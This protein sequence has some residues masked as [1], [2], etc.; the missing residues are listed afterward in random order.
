MTDNFCGWGNF[1]ATVARNSFISAILESMYFTTSSKL[2]QVLE[3]LPFIAVM[4]SSMASTRF[5]SDSKDLPA[6]QSQ[7]IST[8]GPAAE[9]VAPIC[10]MVA[11]LGPIMASF[12][13][14]ESLCPAD[15]RSIKKLLAWAWHEGSSRK[16]KSLFTESTAE[17][18]SSWAT[19]ARMPPIAYAVQAVFFDF[20]KRGSTCF[21]KA[22]APPG[23]LASS[24]RRLKHMRPSPWS[25]LSVRAF[26]TSVSTCGRSLAP[27]P[28]L[29]TACN[30]A[31]LCI[32]GQATTTS[33]LLSNTALVSL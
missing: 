24:F 4:A 32:I 5:S 30:A 13:S 31:P 9:L 12:F 19:W 7:N 14:W 26:P 25:L 1:L 8:I 28:P 21:L 23:T 11:I 22:A 6:Y 10:L 18:S 27:E 20:S 16:T 17:A 3:I 15:F 33:K 2:P 29:T